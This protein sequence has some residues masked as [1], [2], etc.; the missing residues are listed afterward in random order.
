MISKVDYLLQK[1]AELKKDFVDLGKYGKQNYVTEQSEVVNLSEIVQNV[2]ADLRPDCE[3]NGIILTVT[4]PETLNV[5]AKKIALESVIQ[6]LVLNAIEHSYC[7]NL[8]VTAVKR[9]GICRLD[10]VD[11]GKG[12]TTDKDVF[13]PF[14]SGNPS[15]NNSGLGLFLAKNAIETMH[16]ELTYE[17]K[18]NLTIFSAT[19][20]LA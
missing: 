19:L 9:K 13:A 7:S 17:R 2:T 18:D 11:D 12:I 3:A 1:S 8:Y 5:Y 15:E 4:A 14:V 16:G 6:N 10:I 20:P